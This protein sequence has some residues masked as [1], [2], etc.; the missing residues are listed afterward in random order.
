MGQDDFSRRKVP[1]PEQ[2]LQGGGSGWAL[3]SPFASLST[4]PGGVQGGRGSI[5]SGEKSHFQSEKRRGAAGEIALPFAGLSIVPG[6]VQGGRGTIEGGEKSHF[7]SEKRR[8]AQQGAC[9]PI[10]QLVNRARRRAGRSR[11]D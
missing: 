10:H 2:K 4:V 9:I 6:G 3:A 5:E 1:F 7:Q 11:V 8:G